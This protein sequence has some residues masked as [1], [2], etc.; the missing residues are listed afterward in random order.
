MS[1][2]P[3]PPLRCSLGAEGLAAFKRDW[4]Y[5]CFVDSGEV[6]GLQAVLAAARQQEEAMQQELDRLL[7]L[8]DRCAHI[9]RVVAPCSIRDA[10]HSGRQR[11]AAAG[12]GCKLLVEQVVVLS[13]CASPTS[14]V[15][16]PPAALQAGGG[17]AAL[18]P[19]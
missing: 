1:C 14:R 5:K 11:L 10:V 2:L 13:G 16:P 15:A 17:R 12:T 19:R 18:E 8:D 7:E 4:R 6:D 9:L 3:A